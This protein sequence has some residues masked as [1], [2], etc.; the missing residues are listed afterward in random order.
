MP[1][2]LGQVL[3]SRFEFAL[4]SRLE[5]NLTGFEVVS[6]FF[7]MGFSRVFVFM[8]IMVLDR[9]MNK[10]QIMAVMKI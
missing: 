3:T 5:S 4:V 6:E 2:L 10:I 8:V 1:S 7:P 9:F